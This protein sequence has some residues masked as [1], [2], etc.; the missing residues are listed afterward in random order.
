MK[1]MNIIIYKEV[2]LCPFLLTHKNY[3]TVRPS[4]QFSRILKFSCAYSYHAS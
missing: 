3:I 4:A 2:I 1:I